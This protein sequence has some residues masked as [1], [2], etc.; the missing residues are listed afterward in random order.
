MKQA[1][2]FIL[3]RIPVLSQKAATVSNRSSSPP[4]CSCIRRYRLH[5]KGIPY[6]RPPRVQTCS[7]SAL[8][9]A[10]NRGS[11]AILNSNGNRG[12]PCL[13]LLVIGICP[14]SPALVWNAVEA[15]CIGFQ[16]SPQIAP[17]PG[18]ALAPRRCVCET[19]CRRPWR[20][21]G[22]SH[23]EIHDFS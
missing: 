7:R 18:N 1:D 9:R 20:G 19:R 5:S 11:I 12:S 13:T 6:G 16:S 17:R 10:G 23:I 2:F 4:G 14:V 3:S 8:R 22:T 15:R 21:P